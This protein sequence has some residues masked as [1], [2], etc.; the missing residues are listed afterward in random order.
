M[1]MIMFMFHM[2]D[3]VMLY[4]YFDDMHGMSR[5]DVSITYIHIMGLIDYMMK[6]CLT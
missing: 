4:T 2:N 1:Y 3:V 6:F 5:H